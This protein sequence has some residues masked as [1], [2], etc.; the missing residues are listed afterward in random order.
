MVNLIN[1]L[2]AEVSAKV[3]KDWGEN[4][5]TR[6]TVQTIMF[7]A[8]ERGI[9]I[10]SIEAEHIAKGI[11]SQIE[12]LENT[13]QKES[14]SLD[15][16]KVMLLE[17]TMCFKALAS[18]PGFIALRSP[19]SLVSEAAEKGLNISMEAAIEIANFVN[20]KLEVHNQELENS[21]TDEQ[22]GR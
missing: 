18:E 2:Q 11:N 8:E 21:K 19:E 15:Y 10:D 16:R 17:S 13:P 12:F 4:Q 22:P 20:G 6:Y 1:E 7:L 3:I 5:I 9:K 14:D